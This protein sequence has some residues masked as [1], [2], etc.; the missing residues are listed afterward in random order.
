MSNKSKDSA[1]D[2]KAAKEIEVKEFTMQRDNGKP[3][4]IVA[5]VDSLDEDGDAESALQ[6]IYRNA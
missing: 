6:G 5:P 1:K 2:K 4:K 3:M